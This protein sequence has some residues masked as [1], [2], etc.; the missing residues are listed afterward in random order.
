MDRDSEYYRK[1]QAQRKKRVMPFKDPEA[2]RKA[3]Q[4]RWSN[5]AQSKQLSN[6]FEYNGFNVKDWGN[7]F[8]QGDG[9]YEIASFLAS[10]D[11]FVYGFAF[12]FSIIESSVTGNKFLEKELIE[13]A[14]AEVVERLKSFSTL[15]DKEE[16]TFE[17]NFVTKR[18]VL[19]TNP[20]WWIKSS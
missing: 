3:A 9:L 18:Y 4:K 19:V 7:G 10:N 6:D 14:K 12:C 16:Y 17:F 5:Y 20:K 1:M 2:A 15:K 11:S 13:L 8:R